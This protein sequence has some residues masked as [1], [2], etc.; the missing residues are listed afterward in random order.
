MVFSIMSHFN[1]LLQRVLSRVGL[2][3]VREADIVVSMHRHGDICSSCVNETW[4]T[5]FWTLTGHWLGNQGSVP[6][7]FHV[8]HVCWVKLWPMGG[9]AV[10][11]PHEKPQPLFLNLAPIW[12]TLYCLAYV[13][14]ALP[15]IQ[16]GPMYS[17]VSFAE[18]LVSASDLGW[19]F[20]LTRSPIL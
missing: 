16:Y 15:Q 8:M 14:E 3:R 1:S 10:G 11:S 5:W 9:M 20:T 13:C 18:K 19:D 17:G 6:Q 4:T 2:V 12:G 7:R